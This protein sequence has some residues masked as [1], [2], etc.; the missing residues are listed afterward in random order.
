MFHFWVVFL[1]VELVLVLVIGAGLI[2]F[3]EFPKV[4]GLIEVCF[5]I[6][7]D[8]PRSFPD[9]FDPSQERLDAYVYIYIYIYIP[10]CSETI[11]RLFL[12]AVSRRAKMGPRLINHVM[13][14]LIL[15]QNLFCIYYI[16]AFEVFLNLFTHIHV[17][18][19]LFLRH[20]SGCGLWHCIPWSP[21]CDCNS[22]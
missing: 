12:K 17:C 15:V 9:F 5:Q 22:F 11:M 6:A 18:I 3:W 7:E 4:S 1:F 19:C 2:V 16:F 20:R 10:P 8:Q 14:I 13:H 21:C